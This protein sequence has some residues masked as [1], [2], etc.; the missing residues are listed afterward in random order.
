MIKFSTHCNSDLPGGTRNPTCIYTRST[1][2]HLLFWT[3]KVACAFLFQ[4]FHFSNWIHATLAFV[5]WDFPVPEGQRK[6]VDRI[7][8]CT[9]GFLLTSWKQDLKSCRKTSGPYTVFQGLGEIHR[10]VGGMFW[11]VSVLGQT[12]HPLP[13]CMTCRLSALWDC[14]GKPVSM[15]YRYRGGESHQGSRQSGSSR[16]ALSAMVTIYF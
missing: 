9:S 8:G 10:C 12:T 3:Q 1:L 6:G 13:C 14:R 11:V 7:Q 16:M 4:V 15:Q 2:T 5:S